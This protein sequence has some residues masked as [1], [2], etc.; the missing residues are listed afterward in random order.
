MDH[1]VLPLDEDHV[2]AVAA[3][4]DEAA[5][6]EVPTGE[7]S[8]PHVT[9]VAYEGVP[10]SVALKAITVGVAGTP[11]FA[12]RAHGYGVFGSTGD[13]GL[14]LHVPVVR[15]RELDVLHEQVRDA[16][17]GVGAEVAGW[18]EPDVWSPHIT[19][20]DGDLDALDVAAGIACLAAHHHPSWH[21]PVDRL[22]VWGGW[23]ERNRPGDEVRFRRPWPPVGPAPRRMG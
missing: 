23:P 13:G 2:E 19:L 18:T 3:L 5:A 8:A 11:P 6:M 9:L 20:L 16:L 7:W 4:V 21:V 1:V 22:E 14:N 15:G 12:L 10:R 17:L